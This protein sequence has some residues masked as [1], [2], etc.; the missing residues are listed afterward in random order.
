MKTKHYHTY[1]GHDMEWN[2]QK[3]VTEEDQ[4]LSS[5]GTDRT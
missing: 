4:E 5:P 2:P 3:K 1:A